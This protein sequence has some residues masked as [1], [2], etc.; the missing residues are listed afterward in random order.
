MSHTQPTDPFAEGLFRMAVGMSKL[1]AGQ[2]HNDITREA[3][4]KI[5]EDNEAERR[6]ILVA[7]YQIDQKCRVEGCENE[8]RWPFSTCDECTAETAVWA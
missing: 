3:A 8:A 6:K 4:G 7:H 2:P 1:V 5:I